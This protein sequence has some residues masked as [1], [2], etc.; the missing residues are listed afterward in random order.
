MVCSEGAWAKADFEWA[1]RMEPDNEAA[2]R[3]LR[4]VRAQ[5]KSQKENTVSGENAFAKGLA[6]GVKAGIDNF[7]VP[8]CKLKKTPLSLPKMS[9]LLTTGTDFTTYPYRVADVAIY[10]HVRTY[11]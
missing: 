7:T 4:N 8:L 9:V 6:A 11:S 3:E 10:H 5:L 1:L 2:K